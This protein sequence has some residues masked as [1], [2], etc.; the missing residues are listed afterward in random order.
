MFD[1]NTNIESINFDFNCR[2]NTECPVTF[3]FNSCIKLKEINGKIK[4]LKVS[5]MNKMFYNCSNL[6]YLPEFI[7]IDFTNIINNSYENCTN[8]F[9]G[10]HSLRS[11]SENFLK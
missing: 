5:T 7:D 8:A 11:I 9:Y 1:S 10:C 3:M 4:N 6:R 2:A